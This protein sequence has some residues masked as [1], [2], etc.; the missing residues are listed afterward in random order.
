M[1]IPHVLNDTWVLWFHDLDNDK[2]TLDSYKQIFVFNTIEDFWIAMNSLTNVNNGM[3]YLMR[4]HH[5]PIWDHE[6]NLRGGGWTFKISK[7]IVRTFWIKIACYC[8]G[9]IMTANLTRDRCVD[10]S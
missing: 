10:Q 1:S 7:D 6:T 2:W 5:L 3:Y 8:I 4:Q 9:E